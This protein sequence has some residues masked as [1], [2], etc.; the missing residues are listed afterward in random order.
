MKQ[1]IWFHPLYV[2]ETSDS[3]IKGQ[4]NNAKKNNYIVLQEQELTQVRATDHLT[5]A[6]H[7]TPPKGGAGDEED[8]S[9]FYIQGETADQLVKR[10]VRSG[11]GFAPKI[12]SLETCK[13]AVE[14]GI[15]RNLSIHPFFKN[16]F[17]E[18]NPGGHW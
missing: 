14:N 2:L 7:S 12:L 15:A 17:I 13:A 6:G 8:D 3:L 9:G 4:M 1:Y 5:I 10:L 11:L 16:S 18:A